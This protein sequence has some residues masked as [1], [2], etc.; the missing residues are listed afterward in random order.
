MLSW[1]NFFL[2]MIYIEL[3]HLMMM[4]ADDRHNLIFDCD[5]L[6]SFYFF[7]L[8]LLSSEISN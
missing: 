7:L 8:P 2:Y 6:I 4:M 5:I 3:L 1:L